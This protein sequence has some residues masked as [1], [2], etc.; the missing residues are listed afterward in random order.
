MMA[1][2]IQQANLE[3]ERSKA[4]S[5]QRAEAFRK[6]K[7]AY[8][9]VQGSYVGLEKE[10]NDLTG[11]LSGD[12]RWA[13][14][15]TKISSSFSGF[16]NALSSQW[17]GSLVIDE[18]IKILG[19][20][21]GSDSNFLRLQ[22]AFR[23]LEKENEVLKQR[24]IKWQVD[25]PNPH[26]LEDR[27]RIINNLR[28]QIVTLTTQISSLKGKETVSV[29]VQGN[30]QEYEI[31][32]RTLN[33]KIQELESQLRTQ[34][35]DYE[36]QIRTKSNYIKE[37]EERLGKLGESGVTASQSQGG[38][39]PYG[40]TETSG[41]DRMSSSMTSSQEGDSRSSGYNRTSTTYQSGS[42]TVTGGVT[43]TTS[44]YQSGSGSGSGT[45]SGSGI[46]T[47]QS[48]TYTSKYGASGTSGSG[49]SSSGRYGT[50]GLSSSGKYGG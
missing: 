23:A 8:E 32:I 2:M 48:S 16:K 50:S 1:N 13:G 3:I 24:Y 29:N 47:Y 9:L 21:H 19:D 6:M 38:L 11:Q 41:A 40:G 10:M 27:D 45:G 22:S 28:D 14:W 44:T 36:G 46:G 30:T 34:K 43:G 12:N 49:L 15:V 18:P 25:Q 5:D 33:S 31:K 37:L 17:I 7:A 4:I 20:I 26:L 35:I 39:T 42:G